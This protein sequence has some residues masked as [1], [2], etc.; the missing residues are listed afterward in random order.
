MSHMEISH[1]YF[2]IFLML[3]LASVIFFGLVFIASKIGNSFAAKN[4]KK[5]G[6][7]MYECGP[8]PVRQANKMNSQFFIV[9]LVFILLDI[10]VVFL[11]PWALVF[12]YLGWFGLFEIFI[13]ILLLAIGFL[14]AYKKGAFEWQSIK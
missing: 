5:L 12:K 9:A 14:Y 4:R 10:E 11:F 7:G 13:F 3:I 6:L 8:I 2:G 1:P